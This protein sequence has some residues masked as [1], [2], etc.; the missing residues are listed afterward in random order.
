[1]MP[2][3]LHG[4]GIVALALAP[5]LVPFVV[6]GVLERAF[7]AGAVKS[8]HGWFLNIKLA[9]VYLAV[10]TVLSGAIAAV[11]ALSRKAG[12]GGLID[13]HFDPKGGIAVAIAAIICAMLAF[14]FFYYWWHRLQHQVPALWAMHKLHHMDETLGV[15]TQMRCHWLEE[16]GRVPFI[17]VP[18]AFVFNLPIHGGLTALL[19]SVWTGFVHS[20]LRL[21]LGWATPLV[22]GPQLHRIHHSSET[23]HHNC[24]YAALFP[25]YDVLFGTYYHPA[26]NEYPPTG[27][28]GEPDVRTV[29][30]AILLPFI[31][32]STA[33]AA[34]SAEA[35]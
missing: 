17:F 13:L 10:P 8:A 1:M 7:P 34:S 2:V 18:M 21:G 27:V 32:K 6:F 9:I 4:L 24:N 30:Q 11:V 35:E 19:I 12:G 31:G 16:I 5:I 25:I 20:N 29:P 15:S 26:R 14:D 23:R 3:F 22:A 33:V 28:R